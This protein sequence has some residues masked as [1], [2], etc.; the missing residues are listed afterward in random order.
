MSGRY[1]LIV[2]DDALT[3]YA[4]KDHLERQGDHV[5]VAE[6]CAEAR[7]ALCSPVKIDLMVLDY[8]LSDGHGTD[9]LF[10][11]DPETRL[12]RPRIIISSGIVEQGSNPW[13][14]LRQRLPEIIRPLICAYVNKPYTFDSMDAVVNLILSLN[15]S[16]R[17]AENP[18][19][20]LSGD[21]EAL[22]PLPTRTEK[23]FIS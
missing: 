1:I 11:M 9:L 4:L 5:L 2:D 22:S 8:L 15:A 20:I 23:H 10:E 13:E 17:P 18:N 19:E 14:A 16:E 12:Q 3:S 6:S 21:S 7:E